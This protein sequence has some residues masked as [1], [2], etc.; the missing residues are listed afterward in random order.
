MKVYCCQFDIVWENK[1]ANYSRVEALVAEAK[2]E[3]GSLVVLPELF[4]TGFSMNVANCAEA[5]GG[6]TDTFLS[7]LA[8]KLGAFVMGGVGASGAAGRGR[9]EA[10]VYSPAGECVARYVKMQP[11]THGGEGKSYEAGNGIVTFPWQGFTVAPF[12]CYDLRFPELFRAAMRRG[13]TLMTVIASWPVAR[14][15][16]WVTLLQARAIENQAFVVGVNRVGTDP[17]LT[18]TGRSLIVNPNGEILAD[19]GGAEAVVSAEVQVEEVRA[20]RA[21]LP[22]LQ[23]MRP[24]F[25]KVLG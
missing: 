19:A 11:F 17:A 10:V 12:V 2:V 18:Y 22:F 1:P 25:A 16:H 13:A 5:A 7:R 6:V 23:D 21:K 20:Y 3:P 8:Q 15:H 4:A 9:N 14:I 24:E